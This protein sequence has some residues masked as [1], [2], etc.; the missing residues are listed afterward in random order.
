[1]KDS[2]EENKGEETNKEPW[3]FK[4]Y[5]DNPSTFALKS[6]IK[7]LAV[8][9]F[10][11]LFKMGLESEVDMLKPAIIIGF[12]VTAFCLIFY[13]VLIPLE[14]KRGIV[15]RGLFEFE[16]QDGNENENKNGF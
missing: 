4:K 7:C 6:S 9:L 1:M 3:D 2:K 14:K 13:A 11:V 8:T 15:P 10:L 5:G 12:C 16:E